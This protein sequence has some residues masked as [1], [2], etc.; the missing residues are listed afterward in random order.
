VTESTAPELIVTADE[1]HTFDGRNT[2]VEA[3]AI[4][5]GV[6]VDTGPA[7]RVARNAGPQTNRL[8]VD[9]AVL[10]GFCD[11]HMHFEK[12]AYEL[13]MAQLG[14]A[15]TIDEVLQLVADV[16]A[17]V[18][19]GEWIQ[20]F[21]DDNAWHE[22]QLRE[23][24]LPTREELD[25][26]APGHPV[27]LYRGNDAAALNSAAAAQLR[28][29]LEGEPGWRSDDGLLRSPRAR[30]L[31]EGLPPPGDASA[32]L[33]RASLRLLSYGITT[34]VDP[35]LPG[36]FDASW[37][38]YLELRRESRVLQRLY[39]MDRLD[40]RSSFENELERIRQSDTPRDLECD[41]VTGFGLKLLVDGEFNDAWMGAGDPEPAPAA[42][43]YTS[44]E[45]QTALRL[46][47]DRGWPICF[48]VIG[49]GA[50]GAVL[51][52]VERVGGTQAF[53]RNQVTLAHAFFMSTQN[54]DDAVRL[55]LAVS[56]QPLLA[57][58][59]EREMQEAWG[60]HAHR[61]NPYRQMLD[62][63]LDVAGGS[64][65]LPC[66]PLRGAAV[67]V[68]RASRLGS[69]LGIDEAITPGE[70]ISLFTRSAGAYVREPRLGTLDVGAPAD[71]VC[72]P[73]NP[74]D[75]R[76]SDWPQLRPTLTAIGGHVVWRD[77]L[78]ASVPPTPNGASA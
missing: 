15:E 16:A 47:A 33:E 66:E 48:H 3:L 40:Y 68:T 2:V 44:G 55:R 4:A 59:F 41:G 57:Y 25:A 1:I 11:T 12:I 53:E 35:G 34:I 78:A 50:V 31:Q 46:C 18:E 63:G 7:E 24:R 39:L 69:R 6:V 72:W 37:R 22:D 28:S 75:T 29:S 56:V 62:C 61:A 67:A 77:D 74:L 54:I 65:V 43:R 26:A 8:V 70:A 38:L 32:T 21:G 27:F 10:P 14:D 20:S 71:F 42:K 73:T 52:A 19:P 13:R 58:V 76:T 30:L 23:R 17:E 9:G 51:E 45:I 60:D 36:A 64:D 49:R 5:D